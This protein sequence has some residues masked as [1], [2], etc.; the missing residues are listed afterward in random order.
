M[1]FKKLVKRFEKVGGIL[2][3][4]IGADGRGYYVDGNF[5][6]SS[7]ESIEETLYQLEGDKLEQ[8]W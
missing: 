1:T 4:K 2:E 3:Y 5:V 6:T 7:R 8:V